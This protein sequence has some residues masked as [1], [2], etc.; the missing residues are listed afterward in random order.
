MLIAPLLTIAS[1]SIVQDPPRS[2][3]RKMLIFKAGP[4]TNIMLIF[5]ASPVIS[6]VLVFR[7][8]LMIS[9]D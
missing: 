2:A 8:G 7:A 4:V 3:S 5:R 1:P 9:I 6:I